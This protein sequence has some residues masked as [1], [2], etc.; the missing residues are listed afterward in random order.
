MFKK[1][2]DA[3]LGA[4][5]DLK[6][7]LFR[8]IL[9][10]GS[11]TVA[12]AIMQGLFL[13]NADDL[14]FTYVIMFLTFAAAFLLTFK[15]HNIEIATTII[16]IT[17]MFIALPEI[18]L[19]GGGVDSG[20]GLWMCLGVFYVFMMFEG[21]KFWVF[22]IIT[23]LIDISCYMVSF[24]SP[25]QVVELATPFEKHFDSAFAVLTVGITIGIVLKFQL[26]VFERERAISEAQQEELMLMSKSKDVFFASM[27]HEIRTPINT[28]VGLNEL[29]LRE[30]PNEDIQE[31]ARNIQS[32][33]KMLLSLVND[34]LDLSQL[35]IQKME[36]LEQEYSTALMFRDVVDMIQ[37]SAEEKK[38]QFNVQ[39]DKDIPARF[40]GDE[41][42]VKQIL[43]NILNNAVKYTE[44]GS[45]T[46][47]AVHEIREDGMTQLRISVADTGIGI[48]KEEL[49]TLFEAFRRVDTEK[50]HKIQ[51]SGL[52]LSITKYLLDLMGG[53]ISVDSIYT[54]GSIFTVLIP[55]KVGDDRPMGEVKV[56]T[57]EQEK[58]TYYS[59]SFEAPEARVLIVDDDDLNLI[60]TT[61]LLQD[62]K[63]SIDTA[64]S[65]DECLRKTK[66]RY[67]NLILMDYMMPDMDGGSLVREVRRQENGLCKTSSV[68]L[69]SANV[70]AE[71]QNEYDQ[72]G[73]D[74]LLEKPID[75]AKLEEEVL[76]HI[77]DELIEYRRDN[78]MA[79]Q[80]DGF[81]SRVTKKRKKVYITSDGVC[82]M[83]Q[84]FLDKYDIRIIELYVKT[85]Y[86]RFRNSEEI[87]VNNLERYLSNEETLA[88][89]LAP[90]VED[91]EKFF[92]DALMEADDVIYISFASGVGKGIENA[93]NA[94]RGFGHVHVF[95]SGHISCGEA[96]IVLHAAMMA[97]E[98]VSCQE[99]LKRLEVSRSRV[100]TSY[101]LP[102]TSIF[103][104][105]GFTNKVTAKICEVF[106]LH[107]VVSIR[108]SGLHVMGAHVGKLEK[109]WRRFIR[110]H[111]RN[112][113]HIDD[114]IIFIVHAG[115]SVRQQEMIVDEV[116][117]CMKFKQVIFVQASSANVCNAGL[118]SIGFAIYR[119]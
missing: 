96:L 81:G 63:M 12:L 79:A 91:Y 32:S 94:A 102:D 37:V 33:S 113:S 56:V 18:F 112:T 62:T 47:N 14:M 118:G 76:R 100:R 4:Q 65:A 51:G 89:S 84:K 28:I 43:I 41:R 44:E 78:F 2:Y 54:Q 29:I 111:L 117:R 34:I 45:I 15:Y 87:D 119:K 82:D 68:V 16:G 35:E 83:P 13:V 58:N 17:I 103:Y 60:I 86:G 104:Q 8:I 26:G 85:A 73:F 48:R 31:Y 22:L 80:G 74:G 30:N 40:I 93:S 114:D 46:L 49:E 92:A 5:L 20:A 106:K 109:A 110:F 97:A 55:Q 115:C 57:A 64:S 59:K 36:L 67:Y 88:Y 72:A 52:G 69:L 9:L 75:A 71:K 66:K 95:N 38:L 77:P 101:I 3:I 61:K 116:N 6:E 39:V 42:R 70:Y 7:R 27:S 19:R 25:E 99:I 1:Y 98:G 53:E 11:V 107:P 24:Y 105:R 23:V 10:V 90:T 50:N 21:K 108:N